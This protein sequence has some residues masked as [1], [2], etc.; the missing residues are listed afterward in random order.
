MRR[1]QRL[2][3]EEL[4]HR[5]GRHWTYVSGVVG[6]DR[7]FEPK[8]G[9][10]GG[11]STPERVSWS[12]VADGFTR[13]PEY[14]AV[15]TV[16]L[17]SFIFGVA[18]TA[19]LNT[20]VAQELEGT[21]LVANRQGGSVSLFDLQTS[22]EIARIPIGPAIPH[23]VAVS[24]DGR[25][26]LTGEY[27]SGDNPGRHLVVID[28]ENARVA[29]RIDLGPRSRPHSMVF[30][31][32][33]RR[34][35]ATMEQADQVALV[36]IVDLTVLRNYPTGGREG[37]MVRLSR[38]G[39]RAYVTSRGAEG[40]LS[41]IAL[42][43]EVPPVVITTERGA[44]GLAV[45]P[46]GAEVW[47]VNRTVGT[48]SIVDTTRL[49]VVDTVPARPGASRAE[50]SAAGRALVPNGSAGQATAKYL[51]MY[52]VASRRVTHEHPIDDGRP[53]TGAFGI[54]IVGETAFVADRSARSIAVY[55]LADFPN[56][57]TLATNHTAPDGL[58]Y[59]PVRV[60]VMSE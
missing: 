31:P 19:S 33:S 2:S 28:I 58:A 45:T 17:R 42:D 48:I 52:D 20:V 3:Q 59:S 49:E 35:V 50:I 16:M 6:Q 18:L 57:R 1:K 44:E 60:A 30:L 5:A 25:W 51:T 34:A 24:P 41:V 54:H 47:V 55:D 26:A 10:S 8:W 4:A 11:T 43:E 56:A 7:P 40:T 22:V 9:S 23:E 46:A 12:T 39:R 37:H 53:G 21:L 14:A 13:I 27:G 38:D 29:G 36:D 32:D 15:V